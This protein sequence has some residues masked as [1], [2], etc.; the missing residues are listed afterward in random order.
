M[1]SLDASHLVLSFP[2]KDS[3]HKGLFVPLQHK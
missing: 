2:T 3:Y 1:F